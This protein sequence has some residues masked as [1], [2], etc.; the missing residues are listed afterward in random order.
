[1]NDYN[2]TDLIVN[3]VCTKY[4]QGLFFIPSESIWTRDG[5][6][7][8]VAGVLSRRCW[9]MVELVRD[10]EKKNDVDPTTKTGRMTPLNSCNAVA[11]NSN[12]LESDGMSRL[13]RDL[14]NF[15]I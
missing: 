2:R 1:M 13:A 4:I 15:R 6:S 8:W 10:T 14:S 11:A 9:S 3:F 7:N 5:I 12:K